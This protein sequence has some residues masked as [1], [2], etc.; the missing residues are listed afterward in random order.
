MCFVWKGRKKFSQKKKLQRAGIEPATH[1]ATLKLPHYS[2]LTARAT[3]VDFWI[4]RH[5]FLFTVQTT[6]ESH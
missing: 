3:S 4:A 6:P 1:I 5:T 2:V